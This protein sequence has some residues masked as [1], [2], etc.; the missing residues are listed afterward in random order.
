MRKLIN[1]F[2]QCFCKHEFETEDYYFTK[3]SEMQNRKGE[4]RY[5]FCSKCGYHSSHWK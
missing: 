4:R 5:M 2:R 1:Y 3:S